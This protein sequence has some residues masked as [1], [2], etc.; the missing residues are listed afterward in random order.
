[1]LLAAGQASI[2]SGCNKIIRLPPHF[3]LAVEFDTLKF[4]TK[5]HVQQ[6]TRWSKAAKHETKIRLETRN[7]ES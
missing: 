6:K 4:D 7:H 3:C 2:Q 5:V 1:V